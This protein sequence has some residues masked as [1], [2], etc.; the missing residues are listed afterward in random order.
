MRGL[1]PFLRD[2]WRLTRP[3]FMLSDER[4]SARAL[5]AAIVV[6]N[7]ALVGMTVILNFWNRAFYNTLQDKDWKGFFDLLLLYRVDKDG[8]M[9]GFCVIAAVYLVVAVYRTYLNQWLRIRWRR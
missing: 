3:Y 6:L 7:L 2:A 9:P 8:F 4:W 1:G 5:L